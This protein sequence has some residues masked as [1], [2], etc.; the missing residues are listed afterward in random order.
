MNQTKIQA[1]N[2][3]NFFGG[4][5]IILKT[6]LTLIEDNCDSIHIAFTRNGHSDSP[7]KKTVSIDM[8]NGEDV[9]N[10]L[11]LSLTYDEF[12][13]FLTMLRMK[14]EQIKKNYE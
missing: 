3:D 9:A 6:D 8:I 7:S 2:N 10:S 11:S 4:E 13:M 14:F 1:V 12:D 5:S